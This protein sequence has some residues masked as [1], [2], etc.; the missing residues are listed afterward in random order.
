MVEG[1]KKEVEMGRKQWYVGRKEEGEREKG[2][3]V[4]AD[5]GRRL[6]FK[7]KP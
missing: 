6:V 3:R 1:E 5:V 7:K 4:R 2:T